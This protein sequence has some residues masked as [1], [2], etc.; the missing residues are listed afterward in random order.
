ML[1][2]PL[3]EK[4]ATQLKEYLMWPFKT[5]LLRA[6]AETTP[7]TVNTAR[8]TE[9]M[10][11]MLT[12]DTASIKFITIRISMGFRFI[13]KTSSKTR[14]VSPVIFISVMSEEQRN[15][16]SKN[17]HSHI[18]PGGKWLHCIPVK[19]KSVPNFRR[20][21]RLFPRLSF[22]ITVSKLAFLQEVNPEYSRWH[23]KSILGK[24]IECSPNLKTSPTALNPFLQSDMTA[25]LFLLNDLC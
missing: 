8:A 6:R 10:A 11:R 12:V 3:T 25:H 18:Y 13:I 14:I 9:T 5:H 22:F 4:D 23:T 1:H 24:P 19:K 21:F 20:A 7:V 15:T 16:Q 17:E 2:P